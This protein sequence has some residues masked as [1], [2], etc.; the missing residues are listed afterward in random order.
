MSLY[1]KH[2]PQ[3]FA[4]LIG[5]DHIIQTLTNALQAGTYSH[6]Y[7]FAGPKGLG[8]TTLARLFA[9]ALNCTGR[10]L[11]KDSFEPCN[12]CVTCKE[13]VAGSNLDMI[14]IDAAS[15]RGIDEI[16]ELRDKIRFA[17]TRAKYKIYIIDECHM[18][19]KE[20]FNALLKTLEEPPAHA[21][22]ILATTELHKVPATILSRT[23]SFEFKKASPENILKLLK[24]TTKSEDIKIDEDAL[25]LIVRLSSG[26]YRD[27]LSMLDQVSSLAKDGRSVIKLPEV[28]NTL[29]Q[30]TEDEVWEFAENIANSERQKA[31]KLVEKIY[32]D[33]KD[34]E[35]FTYETVSLFRKALLKKEDLSLDYEVSREEEKRIEDITG[36]IDVG[37]II[38]IIEIMSTVIPKVK[39][40]ILG[41]LPLEMAVFEL[42]EGQQTQNSKLKSQNC[43]VKV[44]NEET[45]VVKEK[46]IDVIENTATLSDN[47]NPKATF[48]PEHWK[49]VVKIVKA[50]NNTVAALIN[51]TVFHK[52]TDGQIILAAKFKFHAEQICNK[53]NL[54]VIES[55]V[56][57]VTGKNYK[58]DCIVN[59][60]LDIKKPREAEDELVDAAAEIFETVE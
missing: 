13:I 28:Q 30:T 50:H 23:Q 45:I 57:E 36:G 14:E 55:A 24:K 3:K 7:L 2:R 17:P 43:N 22:F 58:V 19:T 8:K 4:D 56:K 52:T 6:A 16:R 33:G 11:G 40:S 26:A 39:T 31:L 25:K 21:I 34:L 60:D 38:E 18:L 35:Y 15:N 37:K 53:K 44:K 49:E 48:N 29:G 10:V 20:A 46:K 41:Q 9:K 5:Q 1:R 47:K 42:T 32:L 54:V 59:K 27:A 12:K 51:G